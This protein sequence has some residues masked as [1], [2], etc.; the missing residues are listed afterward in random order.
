VGIMLE[1]ISRLSFDRNKEIDRGV[2][3]GVGLSVLLVIIALLTAEKSIYF[4]NFTGLLIVLGGTLAATL[5]HFTL[6]DLKQAFRAFKG[7]IFAP[8]NHPLERIKLFVDLAYS[9]KRHGILV[10]ER[11]SQTTRDNFLKSGLEMTADGLAP[12]EVKRTL[13][14]EIRTSRDRALRAVQV[15]ETMGGYAPAMGLIGTLLGLIQMLG[16]LNNPETVGPAMAIALSTT[17]YGAIL[18][19][20]LLLPVAGKLKSRNS[21]ESLVKTITVEGIL[22]LGKRDNSI[23][24]EQRLQAFLPQESGTGTESAL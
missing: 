2:V 9:V 12:L 5:V 18:A 4:I 1:K 16:T 22:S 8:V 14:N 6:H 19:N 23:V 17:L 3:T 21:E 20:L 24:I 7:I 11:E 13:E 10:L 15:F